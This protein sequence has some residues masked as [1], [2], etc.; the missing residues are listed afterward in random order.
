MQELFANNPEIYI[1]LLVIG[2]L[3]GLMIA[4]PLGIYGEK[5]LVKVKFK[6]EDEEKE[7]SINKK[8][9]LLTFFLIA[10]ILVWYSNDIANAF[11]VDMFNILFLAFLF[12][13]PVIYAILTWRNV[14]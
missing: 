11:Q 10:L 7:R 13:T 4:K 2:T 5:I 9:Y 14:I 12:L 1:I 3:V 6:K 8:G